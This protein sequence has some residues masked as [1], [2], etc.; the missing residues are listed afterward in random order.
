MAREREFVWD[1][2]REDIPHKLV[3]ALSPAIDIT[4]TAF[5]L[6][7]LTRPVCF[8][9]PDLTRTVSFFTRPDPK[10]KD[11]IER[12]CTMIAVEMCTKVCQKVPVRLKHS[13]EQDGKQITN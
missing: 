8:T 7:D 6:P 9:R 1:H 2:I 4:Y 12:A 3:L 13:Y 11:E 5:F 10:L